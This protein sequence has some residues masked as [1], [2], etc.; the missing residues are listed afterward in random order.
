VLGNYSRFVRPNYYRIGVSNNTTTLISAYKDGASGCFA[1]VAANSGGTTVTQ[2]FILKNF[3]AGAVTPW[4]TSGSLSL[5][6]QSP[7]TVSNASF[8]CALPAMSVVTLTGQVPPP[9]TA[10][11][12]TPIA[13]QTVDAGVTLQVTNAA[14]DPDVPPQVLA[15]S[16]LSTPANA[17]LT[18]LDATD[19]VFSWRPLVSQADTTNLITVQVTDNGTPN[20]SATNSFNVTVNPL[21]Q[22]VVSSIAIFSGQVSLVVTGAMGPDYTLLTS[23][24][25]TDWLALATTNSPALPVTLTDTNSTDAAR[26]YRIQI[27]P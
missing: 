12:L 26:F 4:I 3:T 23:T 21:I 2:T 25:L 20:L 14:I 24:N 8:S 5:A 22:P 16:L 10:P 19:A 13:N 7:V 18:S 9:N 6:S 15:F 27:G 1:I 17:T 11:T